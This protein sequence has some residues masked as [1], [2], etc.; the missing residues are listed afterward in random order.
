MS[1]WISAKNFFWGKEKRA[2]NEIKEN[3]VYSLLLK[4]S[5]IDIS[6]AGP[7][8]SKYSVIIHDITMSCTVLSE[9]RSK[10]QLIDIIGCEV[11]KY[12]LKIL[13]K[14][15][16]DFS[17][18]TKDIDEVYRRRLLKKIHEQIFDTHHMIKLLQEKRDYSDY[19]SAPGQNS[20]DYWQMVLEACRAKASVDDPQIL[21]LKYLLAGFRMFALKEP[22]HPVGTPFP[23][24]HMIEKDYNKY[25]C[26]VRD[27]ADDVLYALCPFC[28]AEQ[29]SEFMLLYTKKQR[30][31]K[32]KNASVQNYFTN[33]KG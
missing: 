20:K 6:D 31:K 24:G 9:A 25:Y 2:E 22:G 29:S 5:D 30:E 8:L 13:T 32:K 26:P 15:M 3:P 14:M 27:K 18:K 33:F 16:A 11:E 12:P 21:Y 7:V 19:L 10:N 23:G 1:F 17:E 28:P 4:T